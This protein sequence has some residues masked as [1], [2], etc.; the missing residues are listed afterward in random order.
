M[1]IFK[2]ALFYRWHNASLW[3]TLWFLIVFRNQFSVGYMYIAQTKLEGITCA[4]SAES[5]YPCLVNIH[6]EIGT[7]DKSMDNR[8]FMETG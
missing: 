1:L 2:A 6:E 4:F 7:R 8:K 3:L 5:C